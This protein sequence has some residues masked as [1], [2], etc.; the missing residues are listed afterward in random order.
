MLAIL[1]NLYLKELVDNHAKKEGDHKN[2]A[3]AT[4]FIYK[5]VLK[6]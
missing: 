1:G 5:V 2:E 4:K 6:S 3:E